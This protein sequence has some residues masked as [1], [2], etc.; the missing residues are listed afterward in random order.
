MGEMELDR[1]DTNSIWLIT[2]ILNSLNFILEQTQT[3]LQNYRFEWSPLLF[4]VFG[5][6]YC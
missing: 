3:F 5:L 2:F 1:I 4:F 6:F